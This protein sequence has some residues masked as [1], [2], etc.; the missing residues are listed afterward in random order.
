VLPF[1]DALSV[2]WSPD[3]KRLAVVAR[4][5]ATGPFDVYSVGTDGPHPTRITTSLSV[6]DAGWSR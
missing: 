1:A 6:L 3:G 2:T 4:T 5:T